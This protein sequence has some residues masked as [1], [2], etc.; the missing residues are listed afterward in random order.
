MNIRQPDSPTARQ[1]DSPT[2]RQSGGRGL[3]I[4]LPMLYNNESGA[5]LDEQMDKA[6]YE[7]NEYAI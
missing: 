6:F 5:L 4:H 3:L 7:E 1:P 2:V